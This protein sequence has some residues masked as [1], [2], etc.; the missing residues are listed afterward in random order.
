VGRRVCGVHEVRCR[1]VSHVPAD[2]VL[3]EG[4]DEL[5]G[6]QRLLARSLGDALHASRR[7]LLESPGGGLPVQEGKVILRLELIPAAYWVVV[8]DLHGLLDHRLELLSHEHDPGSSDRRIVRLLVR[9]LGCLWG[10]L[11]R[12][13]VILGDKV[14]SRLKGHALHGRVGPRLHVLV[15]LM[16]TRERPLL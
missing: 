8:P 3:L 1:V 11:R 7:P 13:Q 6:G 4:L 2:V 14:V 5:G 10:S 16:Q 15:A 12:A 9:V